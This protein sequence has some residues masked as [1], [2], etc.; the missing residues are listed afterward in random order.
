MFNNELWTSSLRSLVGQLVGGGVSGAMVTVIVG[1][2]M[3]AMNK[4]YGS[5]TLVA[6]ERSRRSPS[7]ANA[8][9]QARASTCP[10]SW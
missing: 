3:N 6:T 4:R 9:H 8:E 5:E 2:I 1:M 10:L 7:A